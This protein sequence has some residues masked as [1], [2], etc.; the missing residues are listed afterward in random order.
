MSNVIQNLLRTLVFHCFFSLDK[1][2][3]CQNN[4]PAILTAN[5]DCSDKSSSTDQ[6]ESDFDCYGQAKCCRTGCSNQCAISHQS[7]IFLK[8]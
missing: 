1:H 8:F 5:S 6:C 7:K 3:Q 4:N 2:G